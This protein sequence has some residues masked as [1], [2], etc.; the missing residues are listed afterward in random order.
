MG[1]KLG[2]SAPSIS[3][4]CCADDVLLI[5]RAKSNEVR[6]MMNC[7]STYCA[8]SGQSIN[9][10]KSGIFYSNGVHAQF[11]IQVRNLWGLKS[12]SQSTKYLGIPLFRS[13]D[14]KK[15]FHYLKEKL[16]A[17]MSS[18]KSKALSWMACATLIKS[19]GLAIPSYTMA[20]IQLPKV[21]CEEMDSLLRR[22]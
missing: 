8:W 17:K 18:W 6:T 2:V 15:D 20:V 16:E 19:V 1:V 22:F 5:C 21:L 4:L 14:R 11:K 13:C 7:I 3:K 9:L 12:L 10:E